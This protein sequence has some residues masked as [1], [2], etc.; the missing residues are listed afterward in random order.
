MRRF[1]APSLPHPALGRAWLAQH[2][3]RLPLT[4]P[5][6][7]TYM[8]DTPASTLGAQKFPL[9]ASSKISLSSVRFAT[10]RFSRAFSRC[11]SLNW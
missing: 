5:E 4:R 7:L 8:H 3:T 10:A 2:P 6:S 1:I 9:A 11:S